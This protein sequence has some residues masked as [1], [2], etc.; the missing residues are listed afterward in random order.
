VLA[1]AAAA[2]G[3]WSVLAS[4][5]L[6]CKLSLERMGEEGGVMVSEGVEMETEEVRKGRG[7]G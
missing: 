3:D 4:H 1:G 6:T 2:A 5:D 7:N